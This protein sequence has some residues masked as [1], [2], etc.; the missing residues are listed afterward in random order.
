MVTMPQQP[1]QGLS[2]QT[3]LVN[4]PAQTI[5]T[6]VPSG[7]Q[8]QQR[9]TQLPHQQQTQM[10]QEPSAAEI[11]LMLNSLGLG[12]P[13]NETLQLGNWDLKKL[14]MYLVSKM[15]HKC[16]QPESLI[17]T[18]TLR[19]SDSHL[20]FYTFSLSLILHNFVCFFF[21]KYKFINYIQAKTYTF[22]FEQTEQK[23]ILHHLQICFVVDVF[24]FLSINQINSIYLHFVY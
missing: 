21:L 18:H 22:K 24:V 4:A 3:K 5:P 12:L 16:S 6:I 9:I 14:A 8:T 10:Q 19:P 15:A 20:I 1:I 23:H 17:Q 7:Q 2:T 11:N 13:P